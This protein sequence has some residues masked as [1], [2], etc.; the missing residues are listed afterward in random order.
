MIDPLK[1]I[2][3]I[4]VSCPS[5]L[6]FGLFAVGNQTAYQFG[7]VGLMVEAP[8]TEISV[9]WS[10]QLEIV[11]S[12][13]TPIRM[14]IDRWWEWIKINF[15]KELAGRFKAPADL[16]IRFTLRFLPPRH[17]GLGSGT[18]LAFATA[19]ALNSALALPLPSREIMAHTL[20]RGRR[21]AI[22]SYGFF[23]GGLL[24]DRGRQENELISPLDLRLNFPQHWPITILIDREATRAGCWGNEEVVAFEKLAATS[25]SQRQEMVAIVRDGIVRS[26]LQEDYLTFAD[27]VYDFGRRSGMFFEQVQMGAFHSHQV[28]DLI[29]LI[30][31]T[32]TRAVGQSSWGPGVFA[33]S[34]HVQ[35]ATNLAERIRSKYADR[36]QIWQT[37][38][39]NGGV[40]VSSLLEGI[41]RTSLRPH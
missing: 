2:A 21:S 40:R 39:D 9:E 26:V 30:R 29:E 12:E 10:E 31:S 17:H 28:A 35:D 11:A 14:A 1:P 25:E 5:R 24:V 32:P 6:H 23:Q 38:A 41:E 20:E 19:V 33:I 37:V 18:Q 13:E 8:R 7:G 4:L 15:S 22:G 16:P 27:G 34:S 36:Y 3:N